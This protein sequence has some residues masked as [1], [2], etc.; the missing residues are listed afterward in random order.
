MTARS[1]RC[2]R[3]ALK[4][5]QAIGVFVGMLAGA[6]LVVGIAA[7]VAVHAQD[8]VDTARAAAQRW[9][10][11]DLGKP[12]LILVEYAYYGT[13]WPDSSMGCPAPG[14]TP[15]PGLVNGYVWTFTF[16]NMVRYEVHSNYT[17]TPAVLC[18][19]V[20]IRPDIQLSTF[21][22]ATFSLLIPEAWLVFPTTTGG[23]VAFGPTAAAADGDD[24]TLPG[25]RVDPVGRVASGVTPDT[26]LD[27]TLSEMN[28]Q[29]D[30][31]ARTGVGTLGRSTTLQT[32]CGDAGRIWRLTAFLDYGSAFRVTQWAPANEF[33]QWDDAFNNM[34]NQFKPAGSTSAADATANNGTAT[35]DAALTA[36]LAP[37]PLGHIFVGDVFVGALNDLPGRS[38]TITPDFVRRYLAFS[39]DGLWLSYIDATNT[40]LRVLDAAAGLSPH[41][42]AQ[43]V[44]PRF[45]PAWNADSTRVAFVTATDEQND[46]GTPLLAVA[47]VPPDGMPNGTDPERVAAFPFPADCP[48][49]LTDP[50]D[51]A[52]FREA[53][54]DGQDLVLAWMMDE[55]LLVSTRCD[56]GLGLL[57]PA[58]GT[59]T[60]LGDDL[61]GGVLSP[62]RT[63]FAARTDAGLA[64]LDFVNWQRSNL[65]LGADAQQ[66]AWSADSQTLYY[67]TQ[68]L[69]NQI[70]LDDPA[71]QTRGTDVFGTWPVTVSSYEL[72]LVKVDLNAISEAVIWQGEGRG[73]GRIAPA[74]DSSGIAFSL[75][76]S[77]QM[78]ADAFQANGDALALE[79][80][81]PQAILYWL[82]TGSAGARVLA[83]TGQP[84]F[85]PITLAGTP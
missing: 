11:A 22:N 16:D 63:R 60:V 4:L 19:A 21:S 70:A 66:L 43:D 32:D 6:I 55:R 57:D 52:Y 7:P 44:D 23:S 49:T 38:V 62:D 18:G 27:D 79:A 42:V 25:A 40:E 54:P 68:T 8:D 76:T 20:N 73:I 13:T 10:L 28:A 9:L 56:G 47:A 30:P 84:A 85:A 74:P 35:P 2:G 41:R 15:V 53:G 48:I 69:A 80:A 3:T 50:A 64:V 29:D 31:T 45:P 33:A 39:P 75:V 61:R 83:Y 58:D 36:P 78:L 17:G 67:S 77:S 81:T 12:N 34:L 14:E 46:D 82:P 24:C 65:P 71:E 59:L 1:S 5:R 51:S 37:L 26:L 72:T